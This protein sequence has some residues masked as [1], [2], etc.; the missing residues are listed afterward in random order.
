MQIQDY[1]F[2]GH[3]VCGYALTSSRALRYGGSLYTAQSP[4]RTRLVVWFLRV[5]NAA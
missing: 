4:V 1:W 2:Y 3:R 5:Y